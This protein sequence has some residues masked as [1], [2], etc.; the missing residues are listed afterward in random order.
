MGVRT[1]A[2]PEEGFDGS[3]WFCTKGPPARFD[4]DGRFGVIA[5]ADGEVFLPSSV[6][7][8][9]GFIPLIKGATLEVEVIWRMQELR[10]ISILSIDNSTV[11]GA[12]ANTVKI[13]F[14]RALK[15]RSE[16]PSEPNHAPSRFE[17][18]LSWLFSAVAS[19]R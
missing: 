15:Y 1:I 12:P 17:R 16:K 7:S 18:F 8:E 2:V 5:T 3:N 11:P 13:C 14:P 9:I 10:A 4:A 19:K 6:V